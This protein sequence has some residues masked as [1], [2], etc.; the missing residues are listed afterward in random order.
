MA[1]SALTQAR[2]RLGEEPLAQLFSL[3]ATAWD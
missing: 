1:N 3:F 2:Q